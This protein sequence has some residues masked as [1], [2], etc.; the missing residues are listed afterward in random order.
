M[1]DF[2]IRGYRLRELKRKFD[3]KV[4][5]IPD[6]QRSYVW[7]KDSICK[8]MDSIFHNYPVGIALV[9]D[10][11]P[12]KAIHIKPHIKTIIPPF[13]NR[14]SSAEL[15]IDGQQRL[16]TLYAIL[17]G[18]TAKELVNSRINFN[19]LF[20]DCKKDTEARFVFNKGYDGYTKGFVRLTDLINTRPSVLHK[21]LQ[22]KK[23][24]YHQVK[25]CYEAFYNYEF[26]I[27]NFKG[28]D[29]D[30]VREIFIRVNSAGMTISR[31]DNLFALATNV[32]LRDHMYETKRGL[33]YG[34]SEISMDALQNTVALVYGAERIGGVGFKQFLKK[35]ENSNTAEKD[36]L[37]E[38]KKIE[39]GYKEC[40]DFLVS[41]FQIKS[42]RDLPSINI[43]SMLSFFF[44]GNQR[45]A[46]PFQIKQIK[47]WFWHTCCGERYSGR[48]FN[49]N[50]PADIKFFRS[51]AKRKQVSYSINS[52][53]NPYDFLRTDYSANG[54]PSAAYYIMLRDKRPLYLHNGNEILLH[55][56]SA[57]SNRKD[58]HHIFP[59]ALLKRNEIN[60]KWINS[61]VNICFLESDENQSI[62]DSLPRSYLASYQ[63]KKHLPRVMRSHLIP[64]H[65]SSPIWTKDVKK[66]FLPFINLRGKAII[67]EIEKCAGVKLFEKFDPIKRL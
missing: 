35:I 6:I 57:I 26:Y 23:W 48:A 7:K 51:L 59:N 52:K 60:V 61:I 41:Q 17:N 66:G 29:F 54:G 50:I 18:T 43:F 4:F 32:N 3:A 55:K 44:A 11:P 24:E 58:R 28:F 21:R 31:A 53:D 15:I 22:L 64:V 16:S 46:T 1:T 36:F 27:L 13:N 8:L 20:F 2:N 34:F 25:Q 49:T 67:E 63:G 37:K 9:W 38:W 40:V 62:S 65:K 47:K 10:V 30:D 5:A 45:R 39:Y 33:Q 19:E 14:G 12:A 42:L 56:A